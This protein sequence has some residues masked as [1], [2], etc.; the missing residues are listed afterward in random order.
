M[1]DEAKIQLVSIQF[2]ESELV[3]LKAKADAIHTALMV[4]ANDLQAALAGIGGSDTL[5][6]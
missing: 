5:E 2:V 4:Y 1:S 3:R 6:L